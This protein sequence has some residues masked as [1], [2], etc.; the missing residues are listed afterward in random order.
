M[1]ILYETT[2]TIMTVG[3]E[4]EGI[5]ESVNY[6][7][8]ALDS[9]SVIQYPLPDTDKVKTFGEKIGDVVSLKI[10]DTA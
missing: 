5:P 9:G 6:V 3:Y 7:E 10:E 4:I 1:A 2:G 8:I